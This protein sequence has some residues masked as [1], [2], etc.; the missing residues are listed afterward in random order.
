LR[1]LNRARLP[2]LVE[3]GLQR[4]IEPKDQELAW[5]GA[6]PV[7]FPAWQ[8]FGAEGDVDRAIAAFKRGLVYWLML[9]KRVPFPSME[10][11]PAS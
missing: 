1:A 6:N 2:R 3:E 8:R 10:R 9:G 5:H 11:L 7:L 4:T